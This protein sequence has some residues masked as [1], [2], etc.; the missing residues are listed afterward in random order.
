MNK[1]E[2]K[3]RPRYTVRK[4]FEN[5]RKRNFSIPSNFAMVKKGP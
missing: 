3:E 2:Q 4:A 5:Y 1:N